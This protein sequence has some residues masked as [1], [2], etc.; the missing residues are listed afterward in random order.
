M[1]AMNVP[2]ISLRDFDDRRLEITSELM[3]ASSQAGFFTIK[4]HGIPLEQIR[5]AFA[6]SE[7]FFALPDHIKAKTSHNGKNMGWEKNAQ[8]RPSTGTADLKES[9]VLQ[10]A[11]MEG[12]WPCEDDLPGFR[13]QAEAF[14]FAMQRLSIKIMEC[15][16]DALG[17]PADTFTE[18][19]VDPGVGDSQTACRLL[20]Y[21]DLGGKTYDPDQW[22]CGAHADFSLLGLLFQRPGEFGLE[23]CPGREVVGDH[24]LGNVWIPIEAKE[25]HIV[26]N[27]GDQL[28]RWSDDRLKSTFHRV[29]LPRPDEKQGPRYSIAFFN[30]ARSNTIIQGPDRKYPPIT[31]QDFI[32]NAM[33]RDKLGNAKDV[34]AASLNSNIATESGVPPARLV[35]V[36]G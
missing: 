29:R 32:L 36:V 11:R 27:I 15:F 16:A 25:G 18:A 5:A 9:M 28:M 33:R 10:F 31:G 26:C 2:C 21:Y 7:S 24:G 12:M 19:T 23:V 35:P 6:L 4:D 20:H 1:T 3:K 17:L 30:Q 22:R 8:I 34:K 14:M 13:Q